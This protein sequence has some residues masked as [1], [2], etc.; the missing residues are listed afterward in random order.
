MVACI[1]MSIISIILK[2]IIIIII[3]IIV[4]IISRIARLFGIWPERN[5][6]HSPQTQTGLEVVFNHSSSHRGH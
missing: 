6:P 2:S 1:V 3:I 5:D 4:I